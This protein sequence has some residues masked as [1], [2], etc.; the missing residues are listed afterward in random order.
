M[1]GF[2]RILSSSYRCPLRCTGDRS[3]QSARTMPESIRD[4]S[5]LYTT[6]A[7]AH[8]SKVAL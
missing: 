6:V 4:Q 3:N 2:P 8:N 7:G 5:M 1:Q